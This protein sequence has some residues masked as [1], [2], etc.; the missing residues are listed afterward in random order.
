MICFAVTEHFLREVDIDK[1]I[2][3]K[4][5]YRYVCMLKMKVRQILFLVLNYSVRILKIA[6]ISVP[7]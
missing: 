5:N 7:Y 6:N 3:L 2:F 1:Q 4:L